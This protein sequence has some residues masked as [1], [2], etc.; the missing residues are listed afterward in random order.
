METSAAS[1]TCDENSP[2]PEC[3]P[4]PIG[5]LIDAIKTLID[6]RKVLSDQDKALKEKQDA[7]ELQIINAL[8]AQKTTLARG[9]NVTASITE[10]VVPQVCDW[11]AF[12]GYIAENK[13]F[14]MLDRKP[15]TGSFRELN[16]AGI[17][18]PGVD[19]FTKRK[20]SIRKN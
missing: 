15:N 2:Q 14:H 1:N 7:L 12:Y 9:S 5:D 16:D 3:V 20:L 11:E 17:A 18:V 6:A 8:D 4:I 19:A 10:S 13:A